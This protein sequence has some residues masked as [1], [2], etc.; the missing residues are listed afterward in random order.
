MP[1]PASA[2]RSVSP[3][4]SSVYPRVPR[5]EVYM[6]TNPKSPGVAAVLSFLWC[7]LGQIYNGNIGKGVVM[8][9][10]YPICVVISA[11]G[12]FALLAAGAASGTAPN[13]AL[14]V[15]LAAICAAPAL[16]IGGMVGAYRTAERINEA[17]RYR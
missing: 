11:A 4:V 6:V 16:W 7:G 17:A 2:A 1:V 15:T 12:F 14:S 9:V 8:M 5:P 3:R 10:A 13:G